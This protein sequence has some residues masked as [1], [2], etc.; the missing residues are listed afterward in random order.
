MSDDLSNELDPQPDILYY[1][2]PTDEML[3]YYLSQA[4]AT[5]MVYS[6][7]V[8]QL[9]SKLYRDHDYLKRRQLQGKAPT[10]DDVLRQDMQAMAWLVRAAMQYVPEDVRRKAVPPRPPRPKKTQKQTRAAMKERADTAKARD[11]RFQSPE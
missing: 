2:E 4:R 9:V 6:L 8:K 1:L 5:G 7:A 3:V 11:I 10:W